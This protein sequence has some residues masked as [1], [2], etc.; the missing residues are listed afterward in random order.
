MKM[1]H[2]EAKVSLLVMS[3]ILLYPFIWGLLFRSESS[4]S[5]NDH[6]TKHMIFRLKRAAFRHFGSIWVLSLQSCL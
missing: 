2:L 3:Y 6:V 4:T 5:K 1:Y